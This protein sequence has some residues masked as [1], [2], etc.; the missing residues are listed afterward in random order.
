VN[1]EASYQRLFERHTSIFS[2]LGMDIAS[3][4][5]KSSSN[6]IPYDPERNFQPEPDFICAELP[7][8]NIAV[9]ELKT[10]FVGEITTSRQ[11]GNRAKF[12]ASAESYISQTTEYVES[13][14]Q[15]PKARDAVK[16][17]L[18]LER[19]ADYRAVLVYGLAAENDATLISTLLSQRKIPTEI[20][21]YD[22][23]L[24]RMVDAYSRNRNDS[25]SRPGW[26]FVSHLHL[27]PIQIHQKAFLAEYGG[28]DSD[29]VS[30]YLEGNEL[31]FECCDLKQNVHRLS[32]PLTGL[33]PHYVRFEF[34]ND[35]QGA[36]MSLNVNNVETDLRFGKSILCLFPDTELFTLG[37]DS[38]GA[39]GAHF[40]MLEHYLLARTMN[41]EEKLASF[42]HFQRKISAP[43]H[44]IELKPESYMIKDAR[45]L[46]QDREEFKPV[47]RSWPPTPPTTRA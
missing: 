47:L 34:S 43:S 46:V 44:C 36:Y 23:L 25:Q 1:D 5:E 21:F 6:K 41:I 31:I 10:P 8:G 18:G 20:I 40:F 9:V 38:N 35:E 7:A 27:A 3:S 33:G 12:K 19:V 22:Q 2:V 39:R 11:D 37:A 4:F 13:I 26:C 24:D 15:R 45:G 42:H 28:M 30:A 32:A 17:V 29:R 14:R 16:R